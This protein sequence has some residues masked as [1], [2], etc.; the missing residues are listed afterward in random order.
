MD[1]AD[2]ISPTGRADFVNTTHL[3]GTP[4][5]LPTPSHDELASVLY[6]HQDDD[7]AEAVEKHAPV[8]RVLV[9]YT[10]GTIGSVA[11]SNG[12]RPEPNFLVRFCSAQPTF[13]EG[14]EVPLTMPES[15][16]GIKVWYEIWERDPVLDSSAMDMDDW[17]DIA[18]IIQERYD[19]FD[20]F[21]VLHGTDTLCYTASALA[22]MLHDL[23]KPV[24][25][26]GAQIPILQNRTDA[27]DNFR[28][29]LLFAGHFDIPEVTV[30][31]HNKL[32]RACRASKVD[33]SGFEAF[34]SP[35]YPVLAQ[36]GIGIRIHWDRILSPPLPSKPLKVH[37]HMET[38]VGIL[39]LFPGITTALIEVLLRSLK[40]V[41]VQSFGSGNVPITQP[42]L[43]DAFRAA[44]DRGVVIVNITQCLVGSVNT[45]YEA[46]RLLA[47]TG[48]V[49]GHDLTTEAALTKLSSLLGQH[50][51]GSLSLAQVKTLMS[52]SLAGELTSDPDS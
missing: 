4:Y 8:S 25:V 36:V 37:T 18:R 6:P 31:F 34:S 26:T 9:L 1:G 43:L 51:Q 49:C 5:A 23:R 10:G 38:Q 41:I 52:T 48:V 7:D 13:H 16:F 17:V 28:N 3:A 14:G 47:H 27:R 19:D 20:G 24:V 40:G 15:S 22:F 32:F 33:A 45:D 21:V 39:R 42:G 35:N 29:A 12:Y 44:V 50:T 46:G 30:Y 2:V 11:S